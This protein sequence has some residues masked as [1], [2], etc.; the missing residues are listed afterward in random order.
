MSNQEILTKAISQAIN[1]GWA[2]WFHEGFAKFEDINQNL[3]TNEYQFVFSF[4]G[5]AWSVAATT[6]IFNHDFAKA[7]WGKKELWVTVMPVLDSDQKILQASPLDKKVDMDIHDPKYTIN[8]EEW[9]WHIWQMVWS[10]DPIKYLGDN[11]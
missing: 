11:I 10:E 1:G 9:R 6:V 8:I 5:N 3:T 7:T 2:Y 4:E